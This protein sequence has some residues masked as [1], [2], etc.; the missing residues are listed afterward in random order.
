VTLGDNSLVKD[1]II[2]P[3]V[4]VG[5]NCRLT[6]VIVDKG[7]VIPDGTVIGENLEEDKKRFHVSPEG[8]VLVTMEM[9]GQRHDS[10]DKEHL[11]RLDT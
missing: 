6:K 9:L 4:S 3:K 10:R 11:W 1:S 5:K 8:I 2:L 7:C